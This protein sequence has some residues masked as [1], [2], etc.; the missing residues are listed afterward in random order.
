MAHLVCET[1]E[2]RVFVTK[3]GAVLHRSAPHT[4]DDP[5]IRCD[6]KWLWHGPRIFMVWLVTA[7]DAMDTP[8]TNCKTYR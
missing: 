6:S 1:H 4:A 3:D 7:Y 5:P 2:R 8:L